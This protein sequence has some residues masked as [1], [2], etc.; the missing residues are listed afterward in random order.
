MTET[1]TYV[2]WKNGEPREQREFPPLDPTHPAHD[3]PCAACG[4]RLGNGGSVR[5]LVLGPGDAIEE[6]AKHA[7]GR[8]YSAAAVL[9]HSACMGGAS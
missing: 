9:L 5:L 2:R 3:L 6:R 1:V 4:G 8:W 7:E